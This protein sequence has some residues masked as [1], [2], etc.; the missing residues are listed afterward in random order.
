M[1]LGSGSVCSPTAFLRSETSSGLWRA[2][3]L[4]TPLSAAL[5]LR[6]VDGL[7]CREPRDGSWIHRSEHLHQ[8]ELIK[9]TEVVGNVITG[10]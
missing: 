6:P 5:A 4:W 1:L 7:W 2:N 3:E 8:P 9:W 10:C